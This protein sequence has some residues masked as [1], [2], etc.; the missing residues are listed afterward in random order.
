MKGAWVALGLVGLLV[1]VVLFGAGSYI[2]SRNHMVQLNEQVNAAYSE[3]DIQQQRRLDLIPNLVATVK[4][5]AQ[6][7]TTILT[8]IANARAGV[9][10]AATNRP[11][12][13]EAN[14]RLDA[15]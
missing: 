7:E 3:V 15:A 6:V 1:L 11:S 2:S 12:S 8:N 5:Y 9:I 4:G 13:I 10:A 14:Q